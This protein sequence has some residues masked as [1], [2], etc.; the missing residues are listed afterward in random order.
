MIFGDWEKWWECLGMVLLCFVE[1]WKCVGV[2]LN[3]LIKKFDCCALADE[4]QG[5]DLIM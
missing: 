4:L 3:S 5:Y 2:F 1:I